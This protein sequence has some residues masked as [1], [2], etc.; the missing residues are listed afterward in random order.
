MIFLR[1]PVF[2][3]LMMFFIAAPALAQGKPVFRDFI[4][5]V[6]KEDVRTFETAK[7]YKDEENSSFYVEKPDRFRRTI[8]YDFREGKLWRAYY[9]WNGL[10]YA[11]PMKI[12]EEAAKLQVWL[13]ELYGE[14]D[15]EEIEWLNN[16]YRKQERLLGSALRSGD[17]RVRTTWTLPDANVVMEFYRDEPNYA[18]HYTV[19]Q[20][21]K[22]EAN[23]GSNI[24]NLP[25][26]NN[27]QP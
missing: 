10:H 19:E 26:G 22:S 2:L 1:L 11:D 16:R 7:W 3:T 23:G 20:P 27:P 9:G 21:G 25:L 5:G 18:L 8:R 14:P 15:K 24:L 13:E 6:G 12:F 17:I 4:W